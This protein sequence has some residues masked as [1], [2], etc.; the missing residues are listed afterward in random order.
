MITL[1]VY[2]PT[3]DFLKFLDENKFQYSVETISGYPNK[4]GKHDLGT[5]HVEDYPEGSYDGI[6]GLNCSWHPVNRLSVL[7]RWQNAILLDL[8]TPR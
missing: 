5:I 6:I 2:H 8:S 4:E 1:T 3:K 7:R